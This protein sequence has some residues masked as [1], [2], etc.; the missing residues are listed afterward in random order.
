MIGPTLA[1]EVRCIKGKVEMSRAV[2]KQMRMSRLWS[3]SHGASRR[4]RVFA[5][6]LAP[7]TEKNNPVAPRVGKYVPT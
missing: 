5:V 6:T 2:R 1:P 7:D 3:S 4:L